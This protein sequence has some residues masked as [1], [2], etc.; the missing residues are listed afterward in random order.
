MK[1]VKCTIRLREK[2]ARRH[3]GPLVPSLRVHFRGDTRLLKKSNG[4]YGDGES[5]LSSGEV[6]EQ[7][8]PLVAQR[9]GEA[10]Y[11]GC[12]ILGPGTQL[13]HVGLLALAREGAH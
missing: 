2:E 9:R 3:Y 12:I 1:T 10:T 7:V 11:T 8:P 6:P 5:F 4:F 13:L